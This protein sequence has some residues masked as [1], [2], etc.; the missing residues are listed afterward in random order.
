MLRN[1]L[2][3]LVW[4]LAVQHAGAQEWAIKMFNTTSHDFGTVA[5]GSKAQF[6]FQIKNIYEEDAH[7]VMVQSSCGC[8]SVQLTKPNL[9]TFETSEIVADFNT[10]DFQGFRSATITVRLDKPFH[11]E[12]QLHVSGFIRRDVVLQPGAIDWGTVDVGTPAEKTLQVTYAGRD[13]WR[14]VDVK[15]ADPHFEVE[16]SQPMRGP[17]RVS[18]DLLVRMTKDAPV[19][20]VKD[21]LILVTNDAQSRELPVDME[22]RV[23]TDIT[24]SPTKWFIGVVHPGQKVTKN[25]FVRGKKPFKILDVKCADKSFSIEP[26]KESKA[27]HLIPVV[28]TAGQ[29][30]GRI[31]E[32][33]SIR[34]DQGDN[35]VQAFTAF[36]EVIKAD[37]AKPKA[38]TPA[39]DE[40]E[41][42]R[43]KAPV[44]DKSDEKD[45]E[46]AAKEPAAN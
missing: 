2:A 8:T 30:P 3:V 36:A 12:I 45:A 27:I 38:A 37:P 26:S 6:R 14:I 17:G 9:K 4:L 41:A 25:L 20:Y 44:T 16:I 19:G 31:A 39:T 43:D 40:K 7:I 33:I 21:Q 22:G 5:K 23:V 13:D 24:I 46:Q 28:F 11:A 1:V 34:T 42:E 10:R 15:T 35:V 18:Y 32:K 29:D